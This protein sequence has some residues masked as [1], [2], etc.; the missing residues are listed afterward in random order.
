MGSRAG[1]LTLD[2]LG[3]DDSVDVDP[4]PARNR[5]NVGV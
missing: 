3:G 2:L 1:G 4:G 5:P